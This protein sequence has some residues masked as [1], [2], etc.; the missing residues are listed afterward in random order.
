VSTYYAR[1]LAGE[2]L[3]R[4]Y[5]LAPA[6]VRQY[7]DAEIAFV[8]QGIDAS[9]RVLELGCGYGR[10]LRR[11]AQ[12]TR[13]VVGIDLSRESL[14]LAQRER[15]PAQLI[16]MNALT[17]GIR[18]ATFD[19]TVCLQNGVSAIGADPRELLAEALRVTQPGGRVFFSSY[20]ERF[21]DERLRWFELQA[22]H[23]LV[24][25]I[26]YGATGAGTIVC[27]DGFRATTMTPEA[28][29]ALAATL[30]CAAT[31]TEVAGASVVCEIRVPRE[32][33]RRI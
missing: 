32:P 4:C 33:E 25:A 15:V 6:G 31:V 19:I 9:C 27:R 3:K 16:Q 2:R 13:A 8:L 1:S 12:R 10:I 20:A 17:L 18:D 24:G 23:G 7:L 26:D 21:W 22:A 5:E 14:A 28:F 11:L 29:H 30:G